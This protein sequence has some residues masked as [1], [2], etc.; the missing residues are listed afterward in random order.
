MF[1]SMTVAEELVVDEKFDAAKISILYDK[2]NS[3]R[4]YFICKRGN[5]FP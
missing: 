5:P 4:K 1:W 3:K 2:K